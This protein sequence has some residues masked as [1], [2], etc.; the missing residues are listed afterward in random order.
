MNDTD[1]SA[2]AAKS[3]AIGFPSPLL[4][5][6][7]L[8]LGVIYNKDGLIALEKPPHVL[9]GPHPWHE[10]MPVLAEA[11]NTQLRAGK[12]ELLRLGLDPKQPVQPIFHFDP[13]IAGVAIFACGPDAA[14]QARNAFGSCLWK[15]RFRMAAYGGPEQDKAQCDLPVARHNELPMSLISHKTGKKTSTSFTRIERIGRYNIWE[16]ETNY[17]RADQL[18]LHAAELRIRILGEGRYCREALVYLSSLKRDWEGDPETEQP[19]YEA[20]A[21][22][23]SS[24]TLPNGDTMEAAPP[25]RLNNLI[26]QLR[27]YGVK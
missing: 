27:R 12:P 9:V 20:P 3:A 21:M 16:A 24:I 13:S 11:I 18:P 14:Q 23:L 17:Y 26:K 1:D 5:R 7:N 2:P 6:E 25:S 10:R 15:L 4:G 8:R 22:W 19:I